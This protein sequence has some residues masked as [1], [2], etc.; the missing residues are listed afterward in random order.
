MSAG[1]ANHL[2]RTV[3]DFLQTVVMVDDEAF[4][5]AGPGANDID[6]E[7]WEET[8]PD[9]PPV[10]PQLRLRTPAPVPP[11][12]YLDAQATTNAFGS[13]GLA[14]AVL[15][16]QNLKENKEVK[17]PL[18][19]TAQR[20]DLVV[21]D[22]N[23]NDD[24][25]KT[26]LELLRSVLR[27]DKSTGHADER[28]LRVI[29][30]YTGEPKL[31]VIAESTR[32]VVADVLPD[33]IE[34]DPTGLPQFTCGPVRVTVLAKEY[35]QTLPD[36]H[37]PQQVTIA[38]LPKR[39]TD[40]FCT[41]CN[42]LVAAATVA[43]LTGIR[44]EAHR[45]LTALS[46]DLDPAYLGQRVSLNHPVEAERQLEALLTAEIGAIIAD[47]QVG[48][49][50]DLGRIKQWLKAQ[51]ELA[52]GGLNA[53][54]TAAQRLEFLKDGLGDDRLPAQSQKLQRK[55][56]EL[57]TIRKGATELFVTNQNAADRANREFSERMVVRTRYS[58]PEPVLR[59]GVVVERSKEF[60]LCVLPV[61]D[62]VRL[63]KPTVFP[64]LRL[65]R[66]AFDKV[67]SGTVVIRDKRPVGD[68]WIALRVVAKPANLELISFAPTATTEVV[69]ART[70]SG[71]PKFVAGDG[72]RYRWVADLKTEQAQRTVENLAR[73]FSRVGLDEPEFLRPS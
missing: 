67:P 16:P 22:W 18:L 56:A 6:D 19:K 55:S 60:L 70:F 3:D 10:A 69:G 65:E 26:A 49:R 28:R 27:K 48:G 4:R 43:A 33:N 8:E 17:D 20:A 61:C 30:I 50:A 44:A 52:G 7:Q 68:E 54:V 38:N 9:K 45:L 47:R 1:F 41:L 2:R 39:L 63:K 15:S 66:C 71:V 24:N 37:R 31:D 23:L 73:Q 14:C 40:E 5:R 11:A 21:L 51:P 36:E 58:K 46:P 42:G 12:D 25:G 72:K 62:S 32:K 53:A 64:F 59:L 13:R 34:D 29:A 57:K 35:L